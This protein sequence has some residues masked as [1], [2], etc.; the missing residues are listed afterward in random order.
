MS[1][2]KHYILNARSNYM[3]KPTFRRIADQ[4]I[5]KYDRM[6]VEFADIDALVEGI[7]G[8]IAKNMTR[9]SSSEKITINRNMFGYDITNAIGGNIQVSSIG[10][11]VRHIVVHI[12]LLKVKNNE[13]VSLRGA[14]DFTV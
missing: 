6:V 5:E 14:V 2:K 1:E 7:R 4:V 13:D 3:S 10:K 11:T 12:S 8:I 9:D